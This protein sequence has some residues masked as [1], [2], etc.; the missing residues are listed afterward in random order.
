MYSWNWRNLV[1][2]TFYRSEA[3]GWYLR[4]GRRGFH[5]QQVH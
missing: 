5:I 2:F 1:P 4:L 3:G